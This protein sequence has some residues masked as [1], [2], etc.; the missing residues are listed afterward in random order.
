MS[1]TAEVWVILAA[2]GAFLLGLALVLL[3]VSWRRG[4]QAGQGAHTRQRRG[5][6]GDHR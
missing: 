5:R 2:L 4:R 6:G 3:V 1:G